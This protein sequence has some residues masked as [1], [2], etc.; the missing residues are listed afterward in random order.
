VHTSR[1]PSLPP[2]FLPTATTLAL[3]L[4]WDLSGLDLALAGLTVGP[5]GFALRNDWLLTA[6][7]HDAM[8]YVSW[9][10]VVVLCLGVW[11]PVGPLA[12]ADFSARLQLAVST[13]AAAAV[14][15]FLK[16]FS[17]TSCPWDLSAY[18]GMAPYV[19]HWSAISDGGPGHCFP[20]GHA[21]SGYA[22]LGG[23]FAF[24]GE[25]PGLARCW[26]AAAM[27][28][29]LVLGIGQQLRGAHFMSHTLWSGWLCWV[30]ALLIDRAW[31]QGLAEQP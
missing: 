24:R 1:F 25:S 11:W 13:L 2:L 4:A 3:V 16:G 29:G 30:I 14:V 23:F 15:A 9:L 26:L 22:F 8:R 5:D 28:A 20:A 21:S 27:A 12:R 10:L 31:P 6:L 18:G 19:P 17:A 7:M